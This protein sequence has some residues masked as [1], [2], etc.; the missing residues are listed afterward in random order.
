MN[1]HQVVCHCDHQAIVVCLGSRT[2]KHK[3]AQGC[4]AF[5]VGPGLYCIVSKG[6]SGV[7]TAN[8][9]AT[10]SH[11]PPSGSS[12]RLVVFPVSENALCC[13]AAFLADEGLAQQ[14]AKAYLSA[15]RNLQLSLGL[16][17]TRDQSS[18]L[19][20]ARVLAGISGVAPRTRLS[21]PRSTTS[22]FSSQR[23]RAPLY[24]PLEPQPF[25][26][27]F[28]LGET[29]Q[30]EGDFAFDSR[31][32][33]SIVKR[34]ISLARDGA[35]QIH[36]TLPCYGFAKIIPEHSPGWMMTPQPLSA[37]SLANS[38]NA[39]ILW[40][41]LCWPQLQDWSCHHSGHGRSG[42]LD[43]S[44]PW[45]LGECLLLAI[46][47]DTTGSAGSH[48]AQTR[49]HRILSCMLSLTHCH[50]FCP[51]LIVPYLLIICTS[52]IIVWGSIY[53]PTVLGCYRPPPTSRTKKRCDL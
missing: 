5:A 42:G 45:L 50:V 53:L 14:T 36:T 29:L 19:V 33:P 16:P 51:S 24:E 15:V 13:F 52:L 12:G 9:C 44:A 34:A 43:D 18:L 22:C 31:T 48:F 8:T 23:Q 41:P 2:S 39:L 25:F 38:R 35:A 1:K 21:S 26:L 40:S 4:H 11:R 46:Y 32:S 7:F 47:P 6:T 10:G 37:G 3:Q 28:R 27:T 30:P 20:L 49:H 17:G